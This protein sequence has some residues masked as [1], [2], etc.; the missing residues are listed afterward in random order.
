MSDF[1]G[2]IFTPNN[3]PY[4]GLEELIAF[5]RVIVAAVE[6]LHRAKPLTSNLCLS[7]PQKAATLL[8]PSGY[9]LCLSVR[10]LIRQG[11]LHGALTLLRPILERAITVKY[12]RLNTKSHPI[13]ENGWK[14]NQRPK[15]HEMIN[16]LFS[17]EPDEVLSQLLVDNNWTINKVVTSKGNEMVHG[18]IEGLLT[19]VN[20]TGEGVFSQ[21]SK[22]V[23]R[24]DLAKE[25]ALD[26]SAW[27]IIL[28]T[29]SIA[30]FPES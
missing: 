15:L 13:W 14:Y 26:C 24:P 16:E 10:E 30:V 5:D 1:E 3:E 28:M 23:D 11:Y 2:V 8:I 18:G 20:V 9:S 7:T 17:D 12:L 27:L 21:P 4:L 29:E 6:E 25:A 22:V 19:N